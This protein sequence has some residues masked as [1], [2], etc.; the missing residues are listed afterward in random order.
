[1]NILVFGDSISYGAWDEKG[2]W[3]SRLK[4]FLHSQ[5]IENC[6]LIY[7]LSF[8]GDT[9]EN[10]SN[11]FQKEIKDRIEE[12]EEMVIIFAIG[13]NDCQIINS[14]KKTKV[15]EQNFKQN[16]QNFISK[17]KEYS[18]KI[19]F[20]GLTPVDEAKANP[21]S[22]NEDH[23]YKNS[24]VKKYDAIL[25]Q[26]CFENEVLFIFVYDKLTNRDLEDGLHPNSQGHEKLFKIIKNTMANEKL[27]NQNI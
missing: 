3:V 10:I 12:D 26:I 27:T 9:S 1:M 19:I 25:K 14:T 23:S 4:Q 6:P 15:S 2:G 16:I 24:Y 21:V 7:N 20:V 11:R 8:S 5:K 17:S 18:K 22:W 13:I